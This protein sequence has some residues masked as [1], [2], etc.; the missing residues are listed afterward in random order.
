MAVNV[1]KGESISMSC[2]PTAPAAAWTEFKP[3]KSRTNS[4]VALLLFLFLSF[5]FSFFSYFPSSSSSFSRR[6]CLTASAMAAAAVESLWGE[7]RAA[8]LTIL[9]PIYPDKPSRWRL[10]AKRH[11][12][13]CSAVSFSPRWR[14]LL[15]AASTRT[16]PPPDA[17]IRCSTSCSRRMNGQSRCVY[18][19]LG[20]GQ[21]HVV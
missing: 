9:L 19:R 4:S 16:V 17:G 3:R 5:F 6:P 13:R 14:Y 15:S 21:V 2:L 11:R 12:A 18:Q 7:A 1:G 10:S 20:L 8:P